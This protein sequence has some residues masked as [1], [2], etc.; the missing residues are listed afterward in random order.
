MKLT[1]RFLSGVLACFG[2]SAM[3]QAPKEV[4]KQPVS[5]ADTIVAIYTVE[6]FQF[7]PKGPALVMAVWPD[8]T[9]VWSED[10]T[11]GGPPYR[12]SR[13]DPKRLAATLKRIEADGYLEEASLNHLHFGYDAGSTVLLAKAGKKVVKMQSWHE[14]GESNGNVAWENGLGPA[15]EPR[16]AALKRESAKYLHYRMAWAELRNQLTALIPSESRPIEG[17][18]FHE[19]GD[20]FWRTSGEGRPK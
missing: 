14:L 11:A 2:A 17:K 19:A 1:T 13:V 20:V 18:L 4:P 6:G 12:I 10:R 3:A 8:G 15:N 9:A 7:P 16:L 5:T